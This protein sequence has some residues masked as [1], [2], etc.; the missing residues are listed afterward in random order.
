M[1]R[2]LGFLIALPLA[3]HAAPAPPPAEAVAI[4][5]NS[6][7]ADSKALAAQ[8]K[9]MRLTIPSDMASEAPLYS[10]MVTLSAQ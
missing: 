2:L 3:L 5:Y 1:I 8:Q 7:A 6:S 10:P 4:L 9:R